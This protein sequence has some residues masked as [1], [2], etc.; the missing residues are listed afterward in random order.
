MIYN[1]LTVMLSVVCFCITTN[2]KVATVKHWQT[3]VKRWRF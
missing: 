2:G 1:F 3:N